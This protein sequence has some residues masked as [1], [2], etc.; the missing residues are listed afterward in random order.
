MREQI[1]KICLSYTKMAL[2]SY[3]T[4]PE[5]LCGVF[6]NEKPTKEHN[7]GFEDLITLWVV[8]RA[9][10]YCLLQYARTG[11]G[12]TRSP[13][14]MRKA[15]WAILD[16]YVTD[17]NTEPLTANMDPLKRECTNLELLQ[18]IREIKSNLKD[19]VAPYLK[20]QEFEIEW[21]IDTQA[22]LDMWSTWQ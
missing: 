13:E 1:Y 8:F 7:Q 14:L 18:M 10:V 3:Q 4:F 6:F 12:Y 16:C 9:R 15:I 20:Y 17:A 21:D 19:N 22:R 11:N 5:E 2:F